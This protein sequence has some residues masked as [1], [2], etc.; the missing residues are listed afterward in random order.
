MTENIR[1]LKS[2]KNQQPDRGKTKWKTSQKEKV[3]N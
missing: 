2:R 3:K 1:N